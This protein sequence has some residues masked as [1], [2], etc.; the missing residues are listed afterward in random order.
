[1]AKKQ[2]EHDVLRL[3][4]WQDCERALTEGI[5]K[6][7]EAVLRWFTTEVLHFRWAWSS[8]VTMALLDKTK[9]GEYRWR[10]AKN[11]I[12]LI[13]VI[14]RRSA[15]KFSPELLF[16]DAADKVVRPR[17]R[18]ISSLLSTVRKGGTSVSADAEDESVGGGHWH[19]EFIDRA[20]QRGQRLYDDDIQVWDGLDPTLVGREDDGLSFDWDEISR[21]MG[22]T[23]DQSILMKAKAQGV[24]RSDMAK[25]L[26]WDER[27]VERVWRAMNRVIE[28]QETRRKANAALRESLK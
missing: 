15:L 10:G 7:N 27:Q 3:Q 28:K 17:E 8:V 25:F 2:D 21:R 4:K 6:N 14:A 13:N 26:S 5:E 1:M 24:S 18:A 11:P 16:G 22:W 9:A 20:E 23:A 12:G 19:D